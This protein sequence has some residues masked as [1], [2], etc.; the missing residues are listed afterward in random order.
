MDVYGLE[1]TL[2]MEGEDVEVH[3]LSTEPT[4]FGNYAPPDDLDGQIIDL[5]ATRFPSSAKLQLRPKGLTFA[6]DLARHSEVRAWQAQMGDAC[7]VK[8]LGIVPEEIANLNYTPGVAVN[9]EL[10]EGGLLQKSPQQKVVL[11]D[12]LPI[13]FTVQWESEQS[14]RHE[15]YCTSMNMLAQ[16]YLDFNFWCLGREYPEDAC[17]DL[18]L[19]ASR[20][21][22]TADRKTKWLPPEYST[23][24]RSP[25]LSDNDL[26]AAKDSPLVNWERVN[27]W[28]WRWIFRVQREASK[29]QVAGNVMAPDAV[30]QGVFVQLLMSL[31]ESERPDLLLLQEFGLAELC[32]EDLQHLTERLFEQ[33][34]MLRPLLQCHLGV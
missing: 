22:A 34:P 23:L 2:Q 26:A 11:S 13:A 24:G 5:V 21:R 25:G 33:R 28:L 12:H 16:S 14:E 30:R 20:L 27:R 6:R 18:W 31:E 3:C 10:P 17:Q 7:T 19:F 15:L 1:S 32:T 9:L 29:A 4:F 8:S